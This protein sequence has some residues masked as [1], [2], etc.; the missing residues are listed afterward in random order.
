M[1]IFFIII[2]S[3]LYVAMLCL[4]SYGMC[5]ELAVQNERDREAYQAGY[6]AVPATTAMRWAAYG[7]Q[8]RHWR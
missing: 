8:H 3:P 6:G 1:R 7:K 5:F 4:S 2:G